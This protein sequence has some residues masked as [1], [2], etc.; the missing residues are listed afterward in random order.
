MTGEVTLRGQVLP[1]GGIK[2]KV[3]A[4][5][6][7]GIKKIILPLRNRK[8]VEGDVPVNVRENIEFVYVKRV[9]DVLQAAFED[10]N[11]WVAG[12]PAIEIESRL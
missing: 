12:K 11:I 2:E 10:E 4:A 7:A 8:D 6:R 5:H 1:V 9:Y 3:I